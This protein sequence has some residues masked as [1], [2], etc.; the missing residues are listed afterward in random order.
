MK[1]SGK[2]SM[3]ITYTV[4]WWKPQCPPLAEEDD[5]LPV[6]VGHYI[7]D[8]GFDGGQGIMRVFIDLSMNYAPQEIILRVTISWAGRLHF[9]QPVVHQVG[10]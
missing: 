4:I 3:H 8:L 7:W 2:V 5:S 10:L 6:N 1:I 9:L